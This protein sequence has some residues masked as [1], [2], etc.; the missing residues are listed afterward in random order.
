MYNAGT[1]GAGQKLV[2]VGQTDIH[3]TDIQQFR[4]NFGLPANN[5]QVILVPGSP[6][7]GFSPN[8]E[9]EADLDLEWSGAVAR[10]AT[11]LYVNSSTKSGGVFNSATYAIDQNLAPVISM[12]YGGCEEENDSFIPSNEVT[13]QKGSAEGIT[14]VAA[15][16]DSG[17]AACDSDQ[18]TAPLRGWP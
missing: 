7:P 1:N 5:P 14:F 2:V 18:N 9:P 16:G 11:I 8:D 3:L 12:S 15:S 17:A 6:D 13:M 4:T 10:N